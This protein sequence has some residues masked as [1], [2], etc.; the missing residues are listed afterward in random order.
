VYTPHAD[1]SDDRFYW[2]PDDGASWT[3]LHPSIRN[4][5]AFGFGKALAGQGRPALYF[6]GEI[7]GKQ[8]LY[9][10]FDWCASKPRLITRF[11]SQVLASVSCVAGDPNAFGRV[12]VGTSCAGWVEIKVTI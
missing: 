4:V 12:I 8:G 10:S 1:Y 6:W 3:E 11:P 5:R 9:G 2:S 7:E